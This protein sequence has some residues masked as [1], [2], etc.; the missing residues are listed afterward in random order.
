ML[1]LWSSVTIGS[2]VLGDNKQSSMATNGCLCGSTEVVE[3]LRSHANCEV[4]NCERKVKTSFGSPVS[5][6]PT[7]GG[8]GL[9]FNILNLGGFINSSMAISLSQVIQHLELLSKCAGAGFKGETPPLTNASHALNLGLS[10]GGCI[11]G[12]IGTQLGTD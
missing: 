3:M 9:D 4:L 10:L 8:M 7:I 12:V 11:V 1:Q 5:E 6:F 2:F